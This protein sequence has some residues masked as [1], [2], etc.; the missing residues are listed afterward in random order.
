M[1]VFFCFE[2]QKSVSLFSLDVQK[3]VVDF[4]GEKGG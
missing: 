3:T 4:Y 2:L 1:P